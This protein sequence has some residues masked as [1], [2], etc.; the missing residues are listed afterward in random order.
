M[1]KLNRRE[2]AEIRKQR[3]ITKFSEKAALTAVLRPLRTAGKIMD[4]RDSTWKTAW[5]EIAQLDARIL[6]L[7]KLLETPYS[8]GL[9]VVAWKMRD[10]YIKQREELLSKREFRPE[11]PRELYTV[12]SYDHAFLLS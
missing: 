2:R 1:K 4:R 3:Q 5:S 6:R 10:Q 12:T 8:E 7:Q 11:D 9:S